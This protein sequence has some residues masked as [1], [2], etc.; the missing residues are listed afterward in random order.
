MKTLYVFCEGQTEQGFCNQVLAPYLYTIGFTHVPTIRVA[1]S[2]SKGVIHRGGVGSRYVP[3]QR[4]IRNTLKTRRDA[5]VFFTTLLDLY[6]LPG[7]FPGKADN[8]RNPADPTPY[9]NALE[10]AFARD[11]A[12]PRF[13]PHLQLHEYETLL[14]VDPD[15]FA[16]AFEN[17]ESAV[18]ALKTEAAGFPSVEHIDDDPHNAPSKRIIRCLPAYGGRKPTAGPDIAEYIGL[19]RLREGCPHFDAWLQRLERL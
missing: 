9:V 13:V 5:N 14:F 17:C 6:G 1:F 18:Q 10:Q 3:L 16:I 2:K 8:T 15:A 12:D 19:D 11:I 7:D 4:D